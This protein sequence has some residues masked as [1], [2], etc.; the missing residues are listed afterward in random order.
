MPADH[1]ERHCVVEISPTIDTAGTVQTFYFAE[2]GFPATPSDTPADTPIRELLL[3]AGQWQRDLF[4]GD[5]MSGVVRPGGGLIELINEAGVLD[6]WADYGVA[7]AYVVCRWGRPGTAYPSAYETVYIAYGHAVQVNF[8]TVQINL[9]DR[10]F[11]LDK[12]MVTG[13]FAGTGGLEGDGT[14]TGL[15]Q[16][17]LEDPGYITVQPIDVDLRLYWVQEGATS[18][19][20]DLRFTFPADEGITLDFD[21][22]VGGVRLTRG[23]NYASA[24]ELL[25][26]S[27]AAGEVRFWFGDVNPAF[28]LS[29]LGPVYM[30]L[31]TEPEFDV[32]VYAGGYAPTGAPWRFSDLVRRAGLDCTAWYT[33]GQTVAGRLIDDQS[34]YLEVMED[35]CAVQ[36]AFFG[37]TRLDQ[38]Q[39]GELALPEDAD[40][41]VIL[42]T[43]TGT[44]VVTRPRYTFKLTNSDKWERVPVPGMEAPTHEVSVS[45][46]DVWPC[47]CDPAA[48]ARMREILSRQD[49]WV[50]F[51]GTNPDI[52]RVHKG[53]GAVALRTRQRR[54]PGP[55]GKSLWVQNY[56]QLFG[57]L[58]WVL[59][60]TVPMSSTA[61]ALELMDNVLVDMPRLGCTGGRAF[62]IIGITLDAKAKTIEFSLWGG[63]AG[64]GGYV[65]TAS[66]GAPEVVNL[67]ALRGVMAN[68]IGVGYGTVTVSGAEEAVMP[69]FSTDVLAEVDI[70]PYLSSN[71]LLIQGG[72]NGGTTL[73]DLSPYGDTA[74]ITT[75][76]AFSSGQTVYGN[77]TIAGDDIQ[78]NIAAFT[79]SGAG[80]R[81]ARPAGEAWTIGCYVRWN[82]LPNTAPS[83]VLWDWRGPSSRMASL[84]LSANTGKLSFYNAGGA[85]SDIA[86]LTANQTYYVQLT[87]DASN[88]YTIDLDGTQID[89]GSFSSINSAGT[90][91]FYV[92][93][94]ATTNATASVWWATPLRATKGVARSRT[95]PTAAWPIA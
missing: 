4:G 77:N 90:Y 8:R 79:S 1:I 11:L 21:T 53:A 74:A 26:T 95:A 13:T 45:W 69:D 20:Q 66:G 17:V 71:V 49:A 87:V 31:G 44:T 3:N 88:A 58:M 75:G 16:L 32:R 81:F 80:S 37:F 9:R 65:A 57:G 36:Q 39:S 38:F 10:L 56:L 23:A 27:P 89:S 64:P 60:L 30:R 18:G 12:A 61:L 29:R 63:T 52:L 46:G 48:T 67:D 35:S 42:T 59:K 54:D 22:Y 40:H 25:S 92:A 82:T 68:F 41:E 24:A 72:S 51:T 76:A 85:R 14:A 33:T 70:D 7:G 84:Q 5:R 55:T 83:G 62:R 94:M 6:A 43:A 34:T 15:K 47:D 28:A 2:R 78:P 93:S 91:S 50:T 19:Y 86:T 73:Q